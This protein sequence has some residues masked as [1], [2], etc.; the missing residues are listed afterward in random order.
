MHIHDLLRLAVERHAS[1]LHLKIPHPPVLRI[2]GDLVVQE[3]LPWLTSADLQEILRVITNPSQREV[4]EHKHEL[5][6]SYSLSGV[7]RFRVNVCLQ[8][9]TMALSFRPIP[10]TVP[11]LDELGLPEVIK[12]LALKPRGLVLVTGPTGSGK[13]TTLAAMIDYINEN[14]RCR[15]VTVEDPIEFLHRDKQSMIVQRELG[16]DTHSFEAA[17][18]HVLRQDPDV[19]MV[20]EMRDLETIKTTLTAAETGHLILATLH[21]VSTVQTVDRIIDVFPADQ[22]AQIRLQLSILLEGVICQ[23]LLPRMGSKERILAAEVMIN[24]PAVSNLIRERKTFQIPT[25]LQTGAR[26]GMQT[27]DQALKALYQKKQITLQ[28]ALAKS[29]D[30]D[31][32]ERILE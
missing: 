20:G 23:T 22:Q 31:E 14:R 25:V 29:S 15:I 13:S 10:L 4:F 32:L 11:R 3:G 2:Q 21:T 30:P 24:T 6:M 17:L 19:I 9:G 8:R 12:T 18:K 16:I 7:G 5:D 26:L 1:D 28:D 27:L